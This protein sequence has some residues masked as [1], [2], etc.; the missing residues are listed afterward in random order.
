M[1]Q[2]FLARTGP[3]QAE[4]RSAL[5]TRPFA[6]R[7]W[8][9]STIEATEA[10]A[11]TF[12]IRSPRALAHALRAPGELGIGRA[13]VAGLI[14][15]D[16]MEAALDIVDTFEPPPLS[17]RQQALLGLAVLRACGLPCRHARRR[18]SFARAV[19]GTRSPATARRSGT[20]TT[21]ATN[22]SRCSSI[23]R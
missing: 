22:S 11:P 17:L 5:A 3:L 1:S 12:I 18:P 9:G 4:L 13:Y 6:V 8:D 7:F 23:A 2:A 20:T 19:S 14:E 10:N 16:D 21:L 15:V